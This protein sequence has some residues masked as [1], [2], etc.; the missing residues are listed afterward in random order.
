[1][2]MI[3]VFILLTILSGSELRAMSLEQESPKTQYSQ[4]ISHSCNNA[5]PMSVDFHES[6]IHLAD[7]LYKNYLPQYNFDEVKAAV[8]FFDSLR[9]TTD[10][11]QRTTDFVHRIFP[12]KRQRT[13]CTVPEPVEGTTLGASTSSATAYPRTVDSCPLSVDLLKKS[14]EIRNKNI[15]FV[16]LKLNVWRMLK[17][18]YKF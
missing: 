18:T 11:S 14:L 17:T 2:R 9:L 16:E 15:N 5:Y 1:M 4:P 13:M 8:E 12:N 7:S 3:M 10:N 6:Q